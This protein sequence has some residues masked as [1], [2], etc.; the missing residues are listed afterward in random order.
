[1]LQQTR[2]TML[3]G[4]A[5]GAALSAIQVAPATAQAPKTAKLGHSF[6]DSHPRAAAMRRFAEEVAKTTGG[7]VKVEVF[8]NAALGSEEK[9]LIAT[10]AGTIDFYMG[11][12]SPI[13]ARKKEPRSSTSRSCSRAMR[14]LRPCST[15]RR[16]DV[17][18]TASPT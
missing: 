10:Q 6:A 1:M 4:L 15:G 14:R 2:R 13:A 8:G 5:A 16:A 17:Y 11:A 3:A 18:W 9:M 7:S 12:L